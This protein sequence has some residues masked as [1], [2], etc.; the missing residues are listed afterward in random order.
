MP[1]KIL[2]KIFRGGTEYMLCC[3]NL[4]NSIDFFIMRFVSAALKLLIFCLI[5]FFSAPGAASAQEYLEWKDC[6]KLAAVHHPELASAGE[7]IGQA[8]AQIGIVRSPMLPQVNAGADAS[9]SKGPGGAENENYSYS[10]TGRQML[11]DGMKSVYDVKGAGKELEAAQYEY[12]VISSNIRLNLRTAFIQLLKAQEALEIKKD[13]LKRRKDSLD[14][15]RLRYEAGREHKGALLTAE[16]NLSKAEFEVS[17]SERNLTLSR[18]LLIKEMGLEKE[19]V[20]SVKGDLNTPDITSEKADFKALTEENPLLKQMI[21]Q[22]ESAEYSVKSAR[23][24]YFPSVY[25]S[26]SAGRTGSKW[27]PSENQLSAGVEMSL[28]LFEGGGTYYG[29]SKEKARYRQQSADERSTRDQ[30]VYTLEQKWINMINEIEKVRV[31]NNFLTAAEERS[32]IAGSQYS[33]GLISF[34]NWIIIEDA[35]VEEKNNLLDAR[36]NA[37]IAEAEWIQ[38]RGETLDYDR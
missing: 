25:A 20:F 3:I 28:P 16:A 30:V 2:I 7:K 5:V 14:L 36:A 33:I 24:G 37:L 29:A 34:D 31:R 8:R 26:I 35:L 12:M 23:A 9:K 32:R 15:V 18:K 19:G 27:A 11:F 17:E 1:V 21:K 22:R 4:F 38:A 10:I 13:I 6:V